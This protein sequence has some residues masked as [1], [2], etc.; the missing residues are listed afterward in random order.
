ME[1]RYQIFISST[2]LDLKEERQEVIRAVLEL[3]HMPGGMELFPASDVKTW[4]LITDVIDIT[5]YYVLIIGGCYGSWYDDKTSFT[6]KEYDYAVSKEIPIIPFLNSDPVKTEDDV[7]KKEKLEAFRKKIRGAHTP[8]YWKTHHDL[9]SLVLRSVNSIIQENPRPGWIRANESSQ[10]DRGEIGPI[11]VS[12]KL[13]EDLS[14]EEVAILTTLSL[15]GNDA[16]IEADELATRIDVNEVRAQYYI[17]LLVE[18]QYIH[19]QYYMG[20]LP[21]YRLIHKGRKYLVDHSFV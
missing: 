15:L 8:Q 16:E 10:V 1:K 6:E 5:D 4:K 7:P 18:K 19:A 20:G 14:D 11:K 12:E 21:S 3:N 9:K 13:E 17:D 2:Y